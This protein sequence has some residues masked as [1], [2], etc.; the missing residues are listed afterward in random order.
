MDVR[1]KIEEFRREWASDSD[2]IV[3][4]TSGSTGVPK[5]ICLLKDDMI[6]SA[7]ATVRF[8]RLNAGSRIAAAL[9][10]DYI[11]G[12]MMIVRSMVCGCELVEIGVERSPDLSGA[13]PL[14][15]FA[16]VPAQID[17]LIS[18]P[19]ML[20]T[21]RN[22]LIGGAPMTKDQRSK[23]VASGMT[24]WE[25]YGMT[26]TCSHVA[27]RPVVEDESV[28]FVAMPGISF[29]TDSRGCLRIFSE[30]FSWRELVTN[31]CVELIDSSHFR[32]EGRYDNVIIS[33]GLKLH[34]EVLEKEY[35]PAIG[36]REFYVCGRPD[37][38]WGTV[39]VLVVEGPVMQG[40]DV[41]IAAVVTDRRH[42]PKDIIFKENLKRT[43]NGKIIREL[44]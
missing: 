22:V 31:D 19:A 33:G 12:K 34:P 36:N 26:E 15:L 7:R 6:A 39:A 27:L 5:Q 44:P 16:V 43:A 40:L 28:P 21:V 8:F 37:P 4:H 2:F 10:P 24:A 18:R 32:W 9:S 1:N 29:G 14:D 11:A 23:V 25:S 13:L 35:A 41:E 42:L 17:G 38:K 30:S 20:S 3:A